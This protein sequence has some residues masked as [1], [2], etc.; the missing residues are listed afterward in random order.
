MIGLAVLF[1]ASRAMHENATVLLQ[2]QLI[3]LVL[4]V[5]AGGMATVVPLERL[6]PLSWIIGL[7]SIALLVLVLVP[8]I[9]V[10]VNGAQRWI[11][12]GPLRLQAAEFAK[13]GLL[14]VLAHYLGSRP[15]QIPSLFKGFIIPCTIIGL[16]CGLI[17]LQP[18]FGTAALCGVVAM[19]LLFLAGT[20]LLYL[21][22]AGLAGGILF[23]V[24]VFLDPVRWRRITAFLDL[25]GNKNDGAY[26][27]WQ[28]ILAFAAGGVQGVGLG[29]GRQQMSFLPEAH[30]DFIFAIVGEELGLIFTTGIV[31]VFLAIFLLG[32]WQLKKAPNLFQ[33]LFVQGILL[34]IVFQALINFGV[35]TGL[36]PTKGMSLPFISYGGSN[37]VLMF[38]FTGFLIN[39]FRS[40]ERP[41]WQTPREL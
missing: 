16:W 39:A 19:T 14:F 34:F 1:S 11:G 36:L 24:M 38:I 6:R 22:P 25:E 2:K 3:W 27:L 31:L 13:I 26:Q 40:W 41:V 20:R 8:G 35:V 37:L 23:G 28:G 10:R 21:I 12:L 33:F 29:N 32:I 15:R 9:G 18:D 5:V 4:A 7:G 17:F 30:T